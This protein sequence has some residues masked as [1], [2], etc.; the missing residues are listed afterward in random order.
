MVGAVILPNNSAY[1]FKG[2]VIATV[3]GGG[4]TASWEFKGAIKRGA[5]AAST[6]IVGT[7]IKD[8]VAY[9]AGASAWD[10]TFT[11]DTTNGGLKVE[12]TGAAATTIRWV[13]KLETTE[14][15]Y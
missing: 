4:D 2:S 14:V 6:A 7:V 11:A 8:V 1:H 15:T 5:N 3:T 13:A 12:V 10:V 9:D